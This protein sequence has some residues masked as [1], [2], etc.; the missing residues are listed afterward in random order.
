MK[1]LSTWIIVLLLVAA[2]TGAGYWLGHR[3]AG[4]KADT[5]EAGGGTEKAEAPVASVSVAPIRRATV[6]EQITAYGSIIAPVNDVRV[7]SVPFETRV[8]RVLAAPG[9]V[10]SAGEPLIEI[11]ASPATQLMLQEARNALAAAERDLNLVQRRF[12]QHLATNTELFTAQT[13]YKSAQVR[14][15]NLEQSGAGGPRQL[16]TDVPGIVSKVDVQTGQ[17]VPAGGPLIEVAGQTQITARLGVNPEDVSYLKVGQ[18]V[19][20]VRIADPSPAPTTGTIRLIGQRVDP[21]THLVDVMVQ[22]PAGSRLLLDDFVSGQLTKVAAD[23]LVVPREAVLPGDGNDFEL[24]TVRNAKAV[25]HTVRVGVEN[26]QE[27]QVIA[28]DLKEGD[29]AVVVGNYELEDGMAVEVHE[30]P[31]TAHPPESRPAEAEPAGTQPSQAG[32]PE[33][34]PAPTES[35]QTGPAP[36]T[37]PASE[38]AETQ[39]ATAPAVKGGQS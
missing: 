28:D 6:S 24:F 22:P 19:T 1:S 2:G 7:L 32:L 38:P 21:A 31:A 33:T 12:E 35:P 25:K 4:G 34:Q 39:P 18:P 11:E 37:P 27:V 36:T 14:L 30:A 15:Q 17:I 9:Q 20:L 26:D 5:E 29:L 23:G 3:G 10:V 16:K 13:A 8:K